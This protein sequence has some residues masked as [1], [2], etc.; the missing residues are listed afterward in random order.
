M[1][2]A[3]CSGKQTLS[4]TKY[5]DMKMQ[6]DRS[7][8]SDVNL[9]QINEGLFLQDEAVE[10]VAATIHR[11]QTCTDGKR[12]LFLIQTYV[13]GKEHILI[14]VIATRLFSIAVQLQISLLMSQGP[15]RRS[16]ACQLI[17]IIS[18]LASQE[19]LQI[20]LSQRWHCLKID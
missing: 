20:V 12:R 18:K 11:L 1:L 10:Y 5:R 17:M 3:P 6:S 15:K 8:I 14:E 2:T 7:S 9:V 19:F 4:A 16:T 13:I